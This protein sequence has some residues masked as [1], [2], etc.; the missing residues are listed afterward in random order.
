[1]HFGATQSSIN[2]DELRRALV[3]H[4][5]EA[6]PWT[7]IVFTGDLLDANLSTFLRAIEGHAGNGAAEVVGFR[8]FIEELDATMH[9]T[10]RGGLASLAGRWVYVP[11]NHDYKVW[12][13]LAT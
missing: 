8:R 7:E 6:A 10:G 9:A 12:D 3:A 13:L 4:I 5:A 1:M 2:S 11:G